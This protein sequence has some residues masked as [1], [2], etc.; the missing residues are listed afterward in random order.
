MPFP[1]DGYFELWVHFVFSYVG[2]QYLIG[3]LHYRADNRF[4]EIFPAIYG[5]YTVNNLMEYHPAIRVNHHAH[6]VSAFHTAEAQASES[7]IRAAV[8]K[9]FIG[10]GRLDEGTQSRSLHYRG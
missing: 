9:I 2:I 8:G 1:H 6:A 10:A 4:V 5:C 3:D 7:H